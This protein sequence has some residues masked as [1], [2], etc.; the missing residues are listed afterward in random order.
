MPLECPGCQLQQLL[1]HS[2]YMRS[3]RQCE[4]LKLILT[5]SWIKCK[6]ILRRKHLQGNWK[7]KKKAKEEKLIN[8]KNVGEEWSSTVCRVNL[9][10]LAS[11]HATEKPVPGMLAT[12]HSAAADWKTDTA[13]QEKKNQNNHKTKKPCGPREFWPRWTVRLALRATEESLLCVWVWQKR[14][15]LISTCLLDISSH[16]LRA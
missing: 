13:G 10:L 1:L 2:L 12:H 8:C 6:Y 4:A 14:E 11:F 3:H 5:E 9:S 7:K 16:W 15:K